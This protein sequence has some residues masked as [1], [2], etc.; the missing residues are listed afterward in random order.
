MTP[1]CC[2][3]LPAQWRSWTRRPSI[4]PMLP[5]AVPA[6][7][8]A[9]LVIARPVAG[10][11][12][13]AERALVAAAMG[14]THDAVDIADS[15]PTGEPIRL[16]LS[17]DS[18]ALGAQT[19]RAGASP[20]TRHLYAQRLAVDDR[21]D[22]TQSFNQYALRHYQIADLQLPL[23]AIG[24]SSG[25]FDWDRIAPAIVPEVA[26]IDLARIVKRLPAIRVSP[27][28]VAANAVATVR[29]RRQRA[30]WVS[31]APGSEALERIAEAESALDTL[32]PGPFLDAATLR[33]YFRS[34]LDLGVNTACNFELEVWGNAAYAA[35]VAREYADAP[36]M[37]AGPWPGIVRI[38][39]RREATAVASMDCSGIPGISTWGPI[40]ARRRSV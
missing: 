3:W 20:L 39:P 4:L 5:N 23:W 40:C 36:V 17:F 15:L 29:N 13:R 18:R 19:R 9:A 12:M 26:A 8:L 25:D 28:Y 14:Y 6:Q 33:A 24:L 34:H 30:G 2:L 27:Y 31:I 38:A 11:P 7:A 37:R 32:F 22:V 21:T 1:R 10:G 35:D 16:Y